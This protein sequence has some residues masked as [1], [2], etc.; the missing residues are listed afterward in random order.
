V[1]RRFPALLI[2]VSMV[3][4]SRA[5]PPSSEWFVLKEIGPKTFA[6]IDDPTAKQRSYSNGG[7]VVGDDGVIVVDTL[8]GDEAG[9]ALLAAI[10]KV[11]PLPVKFV[12][13]THY[14]ADHVAGNRVF[15]E[16]GAT[17]LAHRDVRGWIHRENLRMLGPNP[18]PDLKL[19]VERFVP[20]T[21]TYTGGID[22]YSG[23]RLVQV[24]YFRGHTG[25]DS[26]VVVPDARVVFGGDLIWRDVVPNMIDGSTKPWIAT[27]DRLV[28]AHAGFTFVP[29]HGDLATA[30]HVRNFRNYMD[31]LQTLVAEARA[32]NASVESI[33]KSV[34]PPLQAK[35]GKWD[36][37]QFMAPMNITQMAEELSGTKSVPQ[38]VQ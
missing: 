36:G 29:G 30:D 3:A 13:N 5:Q 12:I 28:T 8:T 25:G 26:I 19:F 18:K 24:R 16:A 27:L 21:L 7:F 14:H 38:P 15:T 4:L 33:T 37:F 35:F 17:V 22:L 2:V 6:A 20:P 23:N 32:K 31:T 10:R 1:S 34:M 9:A 11:T